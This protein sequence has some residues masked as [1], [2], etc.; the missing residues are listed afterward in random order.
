MTNPSER[1]R[2]GPGRVTLGI[3]RILLAVTPA[4]APSAIPPE[5]FWLCFE[6]YQPGR[7]AD[8]FAVGH[9]RCHTGL[10]RTNSL[11]AEFGISTSALIRQL[12]DTTP[13]PLLTHRAGAR[14]P[15]RLCTC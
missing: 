14:P 10:S 9:T 12:N 3:V 2:W 1:A 11:P 5:E 6:Q 13:S 15:P 8:G 7:S 4:L